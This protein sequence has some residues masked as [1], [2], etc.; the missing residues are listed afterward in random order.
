VVG[1]VIGVVVGA[2][3][4]AAARAARPCEALVGTWKWFT[5]GVVSINPDG[6]VAHDP[7]NDGTWECTD[8]ARGRV[9]LRWRLGDWVNRLALS[10][11]GRALV[12]TDPSQSYVTAQRIGTPRPVEPPAPATPAGPSRRADAGPPAK[13]PQTAKATDPKATGSTMPAPRAPESKTAATPADTKKPEAPP[14]TSPPAAASGTG[15][16]GP[17]SGAVCIQ[18]QV[19]TADRCVWLRSS[20]DDVVLAEVRLA[21]ETIKMTL[22]KPD[23]TKV[24]TEA[25]SSRNSA[26]A[27]QAETKRRFDE[28]RRKGHNIPYDPKVEGPLTPAPATGPTADRGRGWHGTIYD[29]LTNKNRPVFHARIDRAGGC[30][31]D[32]GEIRSYRVISASAKGREAEPVPAPVITC[33]GQACGDLDLDRIGACQLTNRGRR[34]I[35]VGIFRKGNSHASVSS[36]VTPG[37]TVSLPRLACVSADEIGRIEARYK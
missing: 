13:P 26:T 15:R 12:S 37:N 33:V 34:E 19:E 20:V 36:P 17:C 35:E 28:L 22:E 16:P 10:A 2:S 14:R 23:M 5:G 11:D 8:P 6:R 24:V 3:A 18:V 31:T 4:P 32:P 7:G 9:T 29:P 25:R 21:T 27:R 1:I 30:V